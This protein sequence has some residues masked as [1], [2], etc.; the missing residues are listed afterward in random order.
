V[1][2][3]LAEAV[4]QALA[5]ST[6]RTLMLR[7]A[8]RSYVI[9]RTVSRP[10]NLL[11]SMVLRWLA[12]RVT[13]QVI[14]LQSLRLSQGAR[15]MSGEALRL[16]E[17]A[18]CG[19]RVPRIAD[20]GAGHLVLEDCGPSMAAL[21]LDWD[22]PV[23][24]RELPQ[25]ARDL[26]AFH[27]AGHWHGAAQIKNL[28]RRDGLDFRIDFEEDF[29]E[30]LPLAAAQALDLVLFLNS[31]SLRGPIDEVEARVLLPELLDA[32]LAANPDPQ[33]IH[34]LLRA[35]DWAVVPIHLATLV[36]RLRLWGRPRNGVDRLRILTAAIATRLAA[37]AP[38]RPSGLPAP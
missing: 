21:L 31:I 29:G 20:Q 35:L 5:A 3:G 30:W 14:P 4:E 25:L 2:V 6:Q 11:Q 18:R 17:L 27:R 36:L 32:Y 38:S 9:K 12:K 10:R 16:A 26:A 19:V 22:E 33:V 24:R 37:Q 23:W 7:Y 15:G 28:T 1:P 34:M 8:G 13:G